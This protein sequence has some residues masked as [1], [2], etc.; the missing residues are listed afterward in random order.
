M[1]ALKN[2][3]EQHSYGIYLGLTV[4]L[5]ICVIVLSAGIHQS[6][7]TL[8]G[9]GTGVA[10]LALVVVATYT[11]TVGADIAKL[12]TAKMNIRL[13]A[14][15][16]VDASDEVARRYLENRKSASE[17]VTIHTGKGQ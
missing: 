16:D 15:R 10:V 14:A 4:A 8:I 13:Q 12:Q 17:P 1:E 3:Y 2:F 6:D 7:N 11:F 5:L 9:V